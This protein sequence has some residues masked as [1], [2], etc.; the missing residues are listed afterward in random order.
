MVKGQKRKTQQI[1]C[2]DPDEQDQPTASGMELGNCWASNHHITK[3]ISI[4]SRGVLVKGNDTRFDF[5]TDMLAPVVNLSQLS[6]KSCQLS[7]GSFQCVI[8]YNHQAYRGFQ[9]SHKTILIIFDSVVVC[10]RS[11]D[12]RVMCD[13][14]FDTA[15]YSAKD[16][17]RL[18][19]CG[20]VVVLISES[21]TAMIPYGGG[22][23]PAALHCSLVSAE[24]GAEVGAYVIPFGRVAYFSTTLRTHCSSGSDASLLVSCWDDMQLK[25]VDLFS[26]RERFVLERNEEC[27]GS[28]GE[29]G[30][31]ASVTCIATSSETCGDGRV[32]MDYIAVGYEWQ[33]YIKAC[34][35]RVYCGRT[36]GR[37][38]CL[39][40]NG[41]SPKWL[42]ISPPLSAS[43]SSSP[44]LR[45]LFSAGKDQK[46][47]RVWDLLR[48]TRLFSIPTPDTALKVASV[49]LQALSAWSP[50]SRHPEAV[51]VAGGGAREWQPETADDGVEHD[52]NVVLCVVSNE[53]GMWIPAASLPLASETTEGRGAAVLSLWRFNKSSEELHRMFDNDCTDG[54][55]DSVDH[56]TIIVSG[57]VLKGS[58]LK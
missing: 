14:S 2:L 46:E 23:S 56:Q 32:E 6:T 38:H 33:R 51:A 31:H 48:G 20:E 57:K 15:K 36:G 50:S 27:E 18:S 19:A 53:S 43:S 22:M 25:V 45:L 8:P 21:T 40:A 44:A 55:N 35:L 30:L 39:A 16:S 52:T 29:G 12:L 4:L 24:T 17:V 28:S 5:N 9:M 41:C 3:N 47:V 7:L 34:P 58:R 26:G 10:V 42:Q 11:H 1:S 13:I 49:H 37:L 54:G